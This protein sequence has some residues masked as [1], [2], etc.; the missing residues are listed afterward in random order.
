MHAHT[1]PELF[2]VPKDTAPATHRDR[3]ASLGTRL[4]AHRAF[5]LVVVVPMLLVALYLGPITSNQYVSE[6]H[7][8]VRAAGSGQTA[9]SGLGQ[10]LGINSAMPAS[11]TE[12][13]ALG[14]YLTSHD[15]VTALDTRLHLAS[16]FQRPEIDL[17]SR[18][19]QQA[20][21][22]TLLKYYRKQVNLHYSS[23]TG[24]TTMTVR[25]FRPDDAYRIAST[26][27][28]IGEARVNTLNKR[29]YDDALR[30]T[31]VQLAEAEAELTSVQ[32]R[33]T[34]FRQ[35][36][37]DIDPV[38][39]STAQIEL[40]SGMRGQLA[41]ARAQL[42]SMAGGISPSAPQYRVAKK[43]VAA[44]AAQLGAQEARM[45]GTSRTMAVGLGVY[46]ELQLRQDFAAKRYSA[47]AAALEA[48]REQAGRQQL[49]VVRVVEPNWPV[50]P[51]Y[52]Q[53]LVT[54]LSIF[55]GLLLAYGIGWLIAAGV[56]EHAA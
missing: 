52:P 15:A 38:R 4:K 1:P 51:L 33:L 32:Q 28:D 14:D 8:V 47:A 25:A 26:L 18:L 56:R 6:A 42:A 9:A 34:Q 11:Q 41:A 44:L 39:S 20:A 21:P 13:L 10:L 43:R 17:L 30:V 35:K 46:E 36:G 54:L 19:W 5:L 49:F 24:I 37:H 40:V 45:T 22:E 7:F 27:L 2:E 12:S 55:G 53:R 50:K 3:L 23:E 31:R 16:L 48:A 29:G